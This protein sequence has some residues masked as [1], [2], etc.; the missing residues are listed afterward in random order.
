MDKP[1]LSSGRGS[2]FITISKPTVNQ[3]VT[4]TM[5]LLTYI[6]PETGE[7]GTYNGHLI[8]RIPDIYIKWLH[9]W[10]TNKEF[11]WVDKYYHKQNEDWAPYRQDNQI[12]ISNII[13]NLDWLETGDGEYG[14]QLYHKVD[15]LQERHGGVES[16]DC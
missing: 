14:R 10:L 6:N 8:G 16:Y 11:M 1:I 4:L 12:S 3:Q 15:R 2:T 9:R 13:M 7:R 5:D